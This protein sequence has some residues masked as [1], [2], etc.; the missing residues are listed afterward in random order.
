MQI[1]MPGDRLREAM[2]RQ[3]IRFRVSRLR[4]ITSRPFGLTTD[5]TAVLLGDESSSAGL[6]AEIRGALTRGPVHLDSISLLYGDCLDLSA[7]LVEVITRWDAGQRDNRPP[8][9]EILPYARELGR[10][11]SRDEAIARGQWMAMADQNEEP[12]CGSFEPGRI[13]IVISGTPAQAATVSFGRYQ[14]LSFPV[15]DA[16]VTVISRHP[17]PNRPRFDP[18]TDLGPFCSGWA[19]FMEDLWLSRSSPVPRGT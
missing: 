2:G 17:L 12:A 5:G 13:D 16:E 1:A 8:A 3:T 19:T 15:P 10:A 14:A 6:A 4:R 11:A 9:G 18:V 7:P